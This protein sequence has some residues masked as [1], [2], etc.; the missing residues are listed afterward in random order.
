MMF[1]S[2]VLGTTNFN[3][4][5]ILT[6]LA[7][8]GYLLYKNILHGLKRIDIFIFIILLITHLISLFFNPIMVALLNFKLALLFILTIIFFRSQ[9]LNSKR[10]IYLIYF[11]NMGLILLQ[12]FGNIILVPSSII[13]GYYR[14]LIVSR[15]IGLFLSPHIS[16]TFIALCAIYLIA[17]KKNNRIIIISTFFTLLITSSYTALVALI[18][19]YSFYLFEKYSL[20]K[21]LSNSKTTIF[22]LFI[23]V[24][25]T[26][27]Y[28]DSIVDMLK[29]IPNSRY[30]SFAL[31]VPQLIDPD[32][33]LAGISLI[34][35]DPYQIIHYQEKVLGLA[36][37]NESSLLKVLIENGIILGTI[38]LITG[39]R[40]LKKISVFV[41]ITL[42]H[43]SYFFISP[44][45]LAIGLIIKLS[46]MLT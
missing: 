20:T 5:Q 37:G 7:I 46:K 44:F 18:I 35:N 33:L 13:V 22:I 38:L 23:F 28:S 3:L 41:F 9:H 40:N 17:I 31:M 16:S 2:T 11:I 25:V 10:L 6:E 34:P 27:L 21:Y 39:F 8:I 26:A 42:L 30:Y 1:L 36:V 4:L 32:Y 45:I 15:P 19:W 24:Y 29:L 12:Y 43:Y 14:E